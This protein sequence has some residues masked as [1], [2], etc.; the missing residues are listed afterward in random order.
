M[1]SYETNAAP[2]ISPYFVTTCFAYARKLPYFQTPLGFDFF[3][4]RRI[5]IFYFCFFLFDKLNIYLM[6][7]FSN[8]FQLSKKQSIK[9]L[10]FFA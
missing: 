2:K 1:V 6:A 3:C 10:V 9:V 7:L 4:Y 5:N 8:S